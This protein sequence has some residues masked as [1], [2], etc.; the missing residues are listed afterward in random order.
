MTACSLKSQISPAS[1][2][3]AS[4]HHESAKSLRPGESLLSSPHHGYY[5]VFFF[6]FFGLT[7]FLMFPVLGNLPCAQEPRWLR[8]ACWT[9]IFYV[10]SSNRLLPSSKKNF[11]NEAKCKTFVVKVSF[12]CIILKV[13]FISMASH[14]ALKQRL[15]Q[16]GNSLLDNSKHRS[17]P[18]SRLS[19]CRKI[20]VLSY[21][22]NYPDPLSACS[23]TNW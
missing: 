21:N 6:F 8:V 20:N 19:E 15:E 13:I 23:R 4:I 18:I 11:Q 22:I 12:I 5:D 16:L 3:R 14:L 2:N 9:R 7:F 17:R 1:N 10:W